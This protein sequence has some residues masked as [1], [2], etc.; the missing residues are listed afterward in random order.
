MS[1]ERKNE[2]REYISN[3]SANNAGEAVILRARVQNLRAQ[4]NKLCFFQLRQQFDTIQAVLALDKEKISKN[5]LKFAARYVC[6]L[7]N[8]DFK[9]IDLQLTRLVQYIIRVSCDYSRYCCKVP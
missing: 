3:I 8:S 6:L 2:K 9:F 1:R 5:M 4:G 7:F